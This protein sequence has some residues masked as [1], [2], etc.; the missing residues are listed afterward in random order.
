MDYYTPITILIWI[1]LIVLCILVHENNRFKK[2]KKVILYFTYIILGFAALF[3]WLG[4]QLNGNM[5]F[6]PWLIK[7]VKLFDYI[8]T[9]IAGGVVVLQFET[10]GIFKKLIYIFIGFNIVFQ[11]ISFF[12]GWMIEAN[13]ENIYSHG[14]LYN[15][16]IVTY[17]LITVLVIIEFFIYGKKFKKQNRVSLFAILLF[18]ITGIVM[19]EI[20]GRSVR[21]AYISL[22]LCLALL[23]IHNQEFSELVSDE[24]KHE[25]LIRIS[26]DPLTGIYSRYAY[27]Q[28]VNNYEK[29]K[30]LPNDLVCISID[31]NGLK[32]IND[33]LGHLAGDEL[34]RGAS[35]CISNTFK[36]YGK[37]YRTGGDEFIAFINIDS[38][39]GIDGLMATLKDYVDSWSG[40]LAKKLSLSSGYARKCD[41]EKINIEN[42]ISIADR[43]MYEEKN[44]YYIENNLEKRT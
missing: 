25:Q 13:D 44:R 34:I 21:T 16:Y 38:S 17:L 24:Q 32:S 22:V 31:I 9:P 5:N 18:V 30:V 2:E 23:Y 10:K 8:L 1:S 36:K 4:V 43:K 3:E 42:L 33:S 39:E 28:D 35:E 37:C 15:V 41:Y 11:F 26:V 20:L 14:N 12:T 40:T 6:S 7:V 27:N 29:L 19:Q